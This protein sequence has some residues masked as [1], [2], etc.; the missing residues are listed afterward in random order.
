MVSFRRF[1]P[2][3]LASVLAVVI[4]LFLPAATLASGLT[5]PTLKAPHQGQR[6]HAGRIRLV[7]YD[8]GLTSSL[9][10][11]YV[12]ISPKR[13]LDKDGF[14]AHNVKACPVEKGCDF[15]A[16]NRWKGHPGYYVYTAR[17]V[18]PG[19]WA[20]TP[21]RYFWQASHVAPLCAAKGCEVASR[22]HSF[23]VVG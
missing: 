2:S 7:V 5:P 14:L 10:T 19:Y 20:T 16:L 3:A 13:K 17:F 6:V 9:D 11:V 23:R 22:I 12:A 21:H 15:I 1:M 4:L 18:F 8:P